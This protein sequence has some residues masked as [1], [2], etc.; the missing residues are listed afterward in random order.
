MSKDL[1]EFMFMTVSN[2]VTTNNRTAHYS[3][4]ALTCM[5]C[6]KKICRYKKEIA[7]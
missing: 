7:Q 5:F 1:A 3:R 6:T 4:N 2:R